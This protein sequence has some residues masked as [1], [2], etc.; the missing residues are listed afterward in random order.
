MK[1]LWKYIALLAWPRWLSCDY[2]YNQI[3]MAT[4][5]A[6]FAALAGILALLSL[7]AWL[8]RRSPQAF[9][10]GLFFFLAMAP[11]ANVFLI[12]G[13]I[14]AERLLDLPSIRFPGR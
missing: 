4:P 13:T 9:F 6:G 1:I 10:F 11:I 3:P 12:I 8:Y 2:S 5:G 7:A 14:M